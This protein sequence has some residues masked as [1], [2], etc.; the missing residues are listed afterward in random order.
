MTQAFE[1][2]KKKR[3]KPVGLYVFIIL[4]MIIAGAAIGFKKYVDNQ[5]TPIA[6]DNIEETQI[7]IPKGTSTSNIAKILKDNNLIKNEL[8][9]RIFAKYEKMDG[10]FKAGNYLL[11]NGMTPE[12]IM[13]KLVAGGIGKESVTFTIPE[14]FELEQI[15]ERLNEMKIVNKDIFLELTSKASNFEDEFE[16]LKDV[17][18]GLSLE[19]YLYPDTYEVYTDAS[20][21]D[22]IRKMLSRFNNLYSDEIKSKAQELNL[23]LNQVVT[24]ASIIEREG[25]ADSEREIIS[26][27]FH[28]RLKSG[29]MLQ[30]C[31]TVQ[32][33][34]GERKPV[35][36]NQD[37][38][39]DSPYNTY[40][41]LGLP[42]GPIA[43]P[44]I[45]S[46]EAA[47][48]PAEVEYK[49]FVFNEDEA[50][51]HTF[52]VTYEEHLRA[53]NRIRKRN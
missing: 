4:L 29:M 43:S 30:S 27:V 48:N 35:L 20:E 49:Y 16:F 37:T 15:A 9:F 18:E 28:N 51:T 39:I 1:K 22:V 46:I 3:K 26:G 32:Y 23:D 47:V 36:T 5:L 14:G 2:N 21:K 52:S 44:G 10:N 38:S 19:G 41:N 24:L 33:I 25:K 42:P 45:R 17:P 6:I 53:I 12:E 13:R 11:N 31:A 40:M 50:G 7:S 34:L 8:V